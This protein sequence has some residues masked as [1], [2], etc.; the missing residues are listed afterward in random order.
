MRR[1][2][3]FSCLFLS[4]PFLAGS[5]CAF[6]FS[7]GDSD[8][9]PKD[10]NDTAVETMQGHLVGK[11]IRGI[12]YKSGSLEGLTGENGEFSYEVG[13][14]VSFHIGDIPLGGD[15]EGRALLTPIDLVDGGS[16]RHPAVINIA[17]L[18]QSLD[19]TPGDTVITIP[20]S[21]RQAAVTD[22]SSLFWAV[23]TLNFSDEQ[24]FVNAATTLVAV[25]T[26]D[27]PFNTMLVD[28]DTA[29]E[30]MLDAIASWKMLE[31]EAATE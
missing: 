21:V 10:P 3:L 13:T 26:Q 6:F 15:V 24:D 19:A 1:Q 7:T 28:A 18:L 23:Q 14:T 9:R 8:P 25:L 12:A 31:K 5:K 11:P 22:N 2:L 4:I 27:Y 29:R 16:E 17:R 30:T 20:E